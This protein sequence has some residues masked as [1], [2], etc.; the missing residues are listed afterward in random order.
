VYSKY[1]F[2]NLVRVP[3][4]YSY[5][6]RFMLSQF[7]KDFSRFNISV[8]NVS[9]VISV[10]FNELRI[11]GFSKFFNLSDSVL[12]S[13]DTLFSALILLIKGFFSIFYLFVYLNSDLAKLVIRL[14]LVKSILNV[15]KLNI[16]IYN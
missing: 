2:F 15:S 7:V 6:T 9:D 12:L 4:G 1:N 8:S 3:V 13:R 14:T 16:N 5:L 11:L 10:V